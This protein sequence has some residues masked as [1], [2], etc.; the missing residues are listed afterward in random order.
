[1]YTS[2]VFDQYKKVFVVHLYPPNLASFHPHT[3]LTFQYGE[4]KSNENVH[5]I[6]VPVMYVVTLA[7][8]RKW[9]PV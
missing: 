6:S 1:M 8:A 9:V 4:H 3:T 7:A 5:P 2:N